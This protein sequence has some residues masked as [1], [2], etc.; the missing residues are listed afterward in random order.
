MNTSIFVSTP[1]RGFFVAE[2]ISHA[3]AVSSAVSTPLRGFFVAELSLRRQPLFCRV[4]TPLRGFFVAESISLLG[5]VFKV[6]EA[7]F[8]V[9]PPDHARR[10]K[11]RSF[12][13]ADALHSLFSIP[14][15]LA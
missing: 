7:Y 6:P 1:L 8:S 10:E 2:S 4:S 5:T 13:K 3:H 15:T 11:K 12:L 9:P 14:L